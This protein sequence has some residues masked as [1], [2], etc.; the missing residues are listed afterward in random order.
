MLTF[1]AKA[2][3]GT[4]F[5]ILGLIFDL[6]FEML[7]LF[8]GTGSWKLFECVLDILYNIL[9]III[10]NLGKVLRAIFMM[11]GPGIGG[12]LNGLMTGV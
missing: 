4:L 11:L 8:S 6:I 7:A 3:V 10:R 2:L 9:N 12:F 5:D 1:L